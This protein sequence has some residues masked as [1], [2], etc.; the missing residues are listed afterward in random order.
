MW[1]LAKSQVIDGV[2]V[3]FSGPRITINV[4]GVLARD[5]C[6]I[7]TI[8]A[9]NTRTLTDMGGLRYKV[10]VYKYQFVSVVCVR[11]RSC[12]P[13]RFRVLLV[14]SPSSVRRERM[15]GLIYL[16]VPVGIRRLLR[17]VRVVRKSVREHEEEVQQRPGRHSRRSRRVVHGTG[18]LLVTQG[19]FARRR[20]RGCVRGEDVSGKAN[21]IRI[22]RVVLDLLR[23]K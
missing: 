8:Y 4:G 11:V 3:T 10:L 6:S 12:L 19:S 15:D 17:A 9:A 22:T 7:R 20:T 2:M 13:P 18:R 23:R 1:S 21:L 14:T 5:K 16:S